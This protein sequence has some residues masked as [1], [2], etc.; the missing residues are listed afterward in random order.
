LLWHQTLEKEE[1]GAKKKRKYL[2]LISIVIKP[3]IIA[4][5]S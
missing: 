3:L 1:E 5:A 2:T 4:N